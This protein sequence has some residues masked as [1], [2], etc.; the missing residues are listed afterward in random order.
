MWYS[1]IL[2]ISQPGWIAEDSYT[3]AGILRAWA[4]SELGSLKRADTLESRANQR[5]FG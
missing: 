4:E 5:V 1:L 2:G 3:C